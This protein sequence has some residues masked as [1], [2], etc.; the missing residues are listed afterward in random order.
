VCVFHVP[1]HSQAATEAA[2]AAA[3]AALAA[4]ARQWREEQGE[5]GRAL[6]LQLNQLSSFGSNVLYWSSDRIAQ[7]DRLRTFAGMVVAHVEAAGL[8][9]SVNF[10]PH[11]TLAETSKFKRGRG[12]NARR[13]KLDVGT[14]LAGLTARPPVA[15]VRMETA[16]LLAMA[17]K[18]EGGYYPLILEEPLSEAVERGSLGV[19]LAP[20]AAEAIGALIQEANG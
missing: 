10:E 7:V 2:L 14:L 1:D 8:N 13:P 9:P 11:L 16:E 5:E 15:E 4:A 6:T 17:G 12:S 19:D 18:G 20:E 3:K